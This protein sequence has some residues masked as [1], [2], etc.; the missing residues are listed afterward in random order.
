M[1]AKLTLAPGQSPFVCLW[2]RM[3]CI[4]ISVLQLPELSN[5][6]Q[7]RKG[8]EGQEEYCFL[9]ILNLLQIWEGVR[10][11]ENLGI[12]F[13]E[14]RELRQE[15]GLRQMMTNQCTGLPDVRVKKKWALGREKE[16]DK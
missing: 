14:T 13:T 2:T 11:E 4:P 9:S 6:S 12:Y 15:A 16:R 5:R 8:R 1:D 3:M 7:I 10:A